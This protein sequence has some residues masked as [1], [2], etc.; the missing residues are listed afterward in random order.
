M[1]NVIQMA[2][3]NQFFQKQTFKKSPK[4]APRP[5]S[6]KRLDQT[7]LLTTSLNLDNFGNLFNFRF[8][9]FFLEKPMLHANPVSGFSVSILRYFCLVKSLSFIK[10]LMTSLG[11]ICGFASPPIKNPGYAYVPRQC[12]RVNF[13]HT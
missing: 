9:S 1:Q 11:V 6:F 3:K 7:S 2:L 4:T 13:K 8:K 12:F 5:P 10:I